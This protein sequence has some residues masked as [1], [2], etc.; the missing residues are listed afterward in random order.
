MRSFRQVAALGI[1]H[2]QDAIVRQNTAVARA[3]LESKDFEKFFLDKEGFLA[4]VGGI[5]Q[6][7]RELSTTQVLSFSSV[8]D[9][10][11][12]VFAHAAVDSAVTDLCE[13]TMIVAPADWERWLTEKRV[14]LTEVREKSF[15]ELR[16]A[17]LAAQLD[18]LGRDPLLKRVDRVFA[19]CQPDGTKSLIRGFTFDLE[20]LTDIDRLRHAVVHGKEKRAPIPN[21]ADKIEYLFQCGLYLFAMVNDRYDVKVDPRA[22]FAAPAD[23]SRA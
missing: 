21:V 20:R 15:E 19:L 3:I 22:F 23:E 1:E 16:A 17:A 6:M 4:Y 7:G 9:A 13:I 8:V 18:A 14:V 5:E 2:A 11:S 12:L 10:A